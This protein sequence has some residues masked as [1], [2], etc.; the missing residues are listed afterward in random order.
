MTH[1]YIQPEDHLDVIRASDLVIIVESFLD[2]NETNC[3]LSYK[4]LVGVDIEIEDVY[5]ATIQNFSAVIDTAR[6]KTEQGD[7]IT[8]ISS[9]HDGNRAFSNMLLGRVLSEQLDI[10]T[11][12]PTDP[13]QVIELLDS[14]RKKWESEK[15]LFGQETLE[16]HYPSNRIVSGI[17]NKVKTVPTV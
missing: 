3:E 7:L 15:K 9:N 6:E 5:L 10:N 1:A 13:T 17:Y 2:I 11:E 8:V 14:I 16:D 4:D 12:E